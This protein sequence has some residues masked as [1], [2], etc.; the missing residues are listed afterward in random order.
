MG[1]SQTIARNSPAP[2]VL[3]RSVRAM[4]GDQPRTLPRPLFAALGDA[5]KQVHFEPTGQWANPG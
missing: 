2:T 1:L 3:L 4:G 5:V